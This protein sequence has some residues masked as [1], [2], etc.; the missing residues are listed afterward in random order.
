M[1]KIC[2]DCGHRADIERPR[3]PRKMYRF[4]AFW[5]RSKCS[6]CSY[7]LNI[8]YVFY[9]KTSILNWFLERDE[10]PRGLLRPHHGLTRYCSTSGTG[11]PH[12]Q[13]KI[14]NLSFKL[15][16]T[17]PLRVALYCNQIKLHKHLR[18]VIF[19]VSSPLLPPFPL[20]IHPRSAT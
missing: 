13:F 5:L 6:I 10:V 15:C 17:V 1:Q 19:H 18:L 20:L 2:G 7:Q 16:V 4:S 11:P 3:R 8:W 12:I 9:M 14:R